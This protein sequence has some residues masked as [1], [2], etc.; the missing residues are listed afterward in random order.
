M[1]APAGVC[2]WT[3]AAGIGT[4]NHVIVDEGRAVKKFNHRG[5]VN[6]ALA[7]HAGIAVGQEE[8]RGTQAFASAAQQVAGDFADRLKSRRALSRKLLLDQDQVITDEVENVL[9]GQKRDGCSSRKKPLKIRHDRARVSGNYLP[10]LLT[11]RQCR[12]NA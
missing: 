7:I 3:T 2:G 4:V 9:N 6:R 8:E 11:T 12:R 10:Q 5:Q 1:I